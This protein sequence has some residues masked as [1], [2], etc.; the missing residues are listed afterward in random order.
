MKKLMMSIKSL[1]SKVVN[2]LKTKVVVLMVIMVLSMTANVLSLVDS[3]RVY[4]PIYME[5]FYELVEYKVTSDENYNKAVKLLTDEYNA[6]TFM[7]LD[8]NVKLKNAISE[9]QLKARLDAEG[10][11]LVKDTVIVYGKIN[12]R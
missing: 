9:M 4:E 11:V 8:E 6:K 1:S 2:Y 7:L 12:T 3:V 5:L 10:K